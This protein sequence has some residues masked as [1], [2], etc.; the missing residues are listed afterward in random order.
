[1]KNSE[2]YNIDWKKIITPNNVGIILSSFLIAFFMIFILSNRLEFLHRDLFWLNFALP[3]ILFVVLFNGAKS[4][5]AAILK[6][7]LIG[8]LASIFFTSYQWFWAVTTNYYFD[9]SFFWAVILFIFNPLQI[10]SSVIGM[11]ISYYARKG[12]KG[13][14]K[15]LFNK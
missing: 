4:L 10:I 9:E 2:S 13:I 5:I 8:C 12:L 14:S 15:L 3:S 6:G 7:L 1:M 11:V